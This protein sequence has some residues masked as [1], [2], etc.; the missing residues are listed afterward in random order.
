[1]T[2]VLILVA[3]LFFFVGACATD[4]I[5]QMANANRVAVGVVVAFDGFEVA[6]DGKA[7]A[8]DV[9]SGVALEVE[10]ESETG[11][12]GETDRRLEREHAR[13]GLAEPRI[14][15]PARLSIAVDDGAD[16]E[17][18]LGE[19]R[20]RRGEGN[21]DRGPV[22][23]A[24]RRGDG[25]VGEAE[26]AVDGAAGAVANHGGVGQRLDTDRG[27]RCGG[28]VDDHGVGVEARV[29]AGDEDGVD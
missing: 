9:V 27:Q 26:V 1:M 23:G 18:A 11:A 14:D 2:R 8:T 19:R 6:G 15:G 5:R 12:A 17:P 16:G 22:A 24:R 25:E 28:R 29:L 13:V 20:L 7:R 21:I 10:F 4:T 3:L